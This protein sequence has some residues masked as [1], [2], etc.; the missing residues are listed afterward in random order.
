MGGCSSTASG[1]GG[2]GDNVDGNFNTD[3]ELICG[4]LKQFSREDLHDLT[5]GKLKIGE[6][7]FDSPL[8]RKALLQENY[9]HIYDRTFEKANKDNITKLQTRARSWLAFKRFQGHLKRQIEH[10]FLNPPSYFRREENWETIQSGDVRVEMISRENTEN[11]TYAKSMRVLDFII[12]DHQVKH[13]YES[14]GASYV[15]Q[16]LGG[17]RHGEGKMEWTDGASYA[18]TWRCN[19]ASRYGKFTYPNGD[20]YEGGWAS[21]L[22][23]GYGV[24]RHAN[25][26]VYRG[27]WLQ[28]QMHGKGEETWADGSQYLGDYCSG[29]KE[30][31]GTYLWTDGSRFYGEWEHN[32][33]N[34]YGMI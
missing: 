10:D 26:L 29:S 22:M 18:G 24:Y 23:C 19:Q 27:Q 32:E 13:D 7:G 9:T 11:K 34:G 12:N 2:C 21:N 14:T 30:G 8:A 25:G 20:I 31:A 17:M 16:W 15:G 1:C 28:G 4:S 33:I 3:G 5:G 6:N